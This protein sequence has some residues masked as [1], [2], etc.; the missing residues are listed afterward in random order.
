MAATPS[1]ARWL[2]TPAERAKFREHVAATYEQPA[3]HTYAS[4]A[5]AAFLDMV[6]LLNAPRVTVEAAGSAGP[7]TWVEA[8]RTD[9]ATAYR[10]GTA[11]GGVPTTLGVGVVS[12][13][14]P[15]EVF[16]IVSTFA[17]RKRWDP[18]F[19]N[20]RLVRTLDATAM[21]ACATSPSQWPVASREVICVSATRVKPD[22]SIINVS[23]SIDEPS[24]PVKSGCVRADLWLAGWH[25]E[26]TT[27][28]GAPAT[29]VRSR[30]CA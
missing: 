25:L 20:G 28:N 1:F 19:E 21:V 29:K 27:D 17:T 15:A 8:K 26:P 2:G 12:G 5:D 18:L 22:G 30:K 16:A 11:G 7:D 24:I 6:T 4:V 14:T 23:R 13:L 10:L 3:T 9:D